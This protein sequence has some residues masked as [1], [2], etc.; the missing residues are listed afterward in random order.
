ME[1][2]SDFRTFSAFQ[3]YSTERGTEKEINVMVD[4]LWMKDNRVYFRV[5]EGIPKNA[6]IFKKE[7][8]EDFYSIKKE[9]LLCIRC[10]LYIK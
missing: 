10:R 7:Q 8:K 4:K 5:V 9:D 2:K 1:S 3:I 6:R